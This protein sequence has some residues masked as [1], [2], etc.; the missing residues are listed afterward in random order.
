MVTLT[1]HDQD[2]DPRKRWLDNVKEDWAT[3]QLTLP[4]ADRLAKDR[5]G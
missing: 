5:S 3:L 2:E 1:V 4:E